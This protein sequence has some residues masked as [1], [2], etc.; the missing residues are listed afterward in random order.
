M[1]NKLLTELTEDL[2]RLYFI[3]VYMSM[4]FF[5]LFYCA[6]MLFNVFHIVSRG[7]CLCIVVSRSVS[8]KREF[9]LMTQ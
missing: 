2:L 7:R 8:M 4:Y 1:Q 6:E 3:H 9:M 5:I